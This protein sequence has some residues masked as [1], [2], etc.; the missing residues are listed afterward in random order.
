MGGW[1]LWLQEM[2][3][4]NNIYHGTMPGTRTTKELNRSV[5]FWLEQKKRFSSTSWGKW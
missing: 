1:R 5:Q 3:G 4:N 2:A